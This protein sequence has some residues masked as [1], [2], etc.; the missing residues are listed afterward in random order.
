MTT[1]PETRAR[2]TGEKCHLVAPPPSQPHSCRVRRKHARKERNAD[3]KQPAI[4]NIQASETRMKKHRRRSGGGKNGRL[5]QQLRLRHH[6]RLLLRVLWEEA[7]FHSAKCTSSTEASRALDHLLRTVERIP[8][9]RPCNCSRRLHRLLLLWQMITRFQQMTSP[10]EAPGDA[11]GERGPPHHTCR[12]HR[13]HIRKERNVDKT[14]QRHRKRSSLR[15]Q[16]RL[17]RHRLRVL[18]GEARFRSGK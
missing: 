16:P 18:W 4:S 1:P 15:Q 14:H 17:R 11:T 10:L 8:L 7:R 2:T 5:H 3:E 9:L 6:R 13:K 12:V